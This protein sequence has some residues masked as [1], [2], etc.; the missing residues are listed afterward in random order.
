VCFVIVQSLRL[1]SNLKGRGCIG[2]G[3][4]IYNELLPLCCILICVNNEINR[5][6]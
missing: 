4:N 2:S 3:F 5:T 1:R 6:N